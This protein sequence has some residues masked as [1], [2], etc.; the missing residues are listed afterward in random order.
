MIPCQ[1]INSLEENIFIAGN[2]QTLEFEC[3]DE[4]GTI[5][6]LTTATVSLLLSPYGNPSVTSLI[7]EGV[8]FDT[9]KFTVT[10][11]KEDTINM[12]GVYSFQP[13]II[14]VTQ[15]ELRPIQGT[16]FIQ[17]AIKTI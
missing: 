2:R 7:K 5:V 1:T 10:F 8:V 12:R 4:D 9:N 15:K 3:Y 16:L 17:E 11:E 14:D 6:D 13:L